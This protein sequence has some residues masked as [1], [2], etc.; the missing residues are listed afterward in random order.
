MTQEINS[1]ATLL[2]KVFTIVNK[3]LL[4]PRAML[5]QKTRPVLSVRIFFVFLHGLEPRSSEPESDMLPLHHR[6]FK[7]AGRISTQTCYREP[8]EVPAANI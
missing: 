6:K 2:K 5:K 4:M 3:H 1:I 7:Y 8:G